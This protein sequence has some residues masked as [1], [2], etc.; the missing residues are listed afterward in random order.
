MKMDKDTFWQIIDSVNSEVSGADPQEILRATRE[1][2]L[3][4][5]PREI[6]VWANILRYYRELA[7]T[8]GIF[9]ASCVL[10]EYMSDDGFMDFRAWLISSGKEVYLAALKNP[11]SLAGLEIPENTRFELYGYVAYDAFKS[12]CRDDVYEVMK[13]NPLTKAHKA[14]IRAEIKYFPLEIDYLHVKLHLPDLYAKHM[15]PGVGL[16]FIYRQGS[17]RNY[18][19][20][21]PDMTELEKL[22]KAAALI[23]EMTGGRQT[24]RAGIGGAYIVA[25]EDADLGMQ[26]RVKSSDVPDHFR[27]AFT[28]YSRKMG[29]EMASGGLRSL[30]TEAGQ[31][32][33]LLMALE[34]QDFHPSSGEL[35]QFAEGIEQKQET[36]PVM[37][38]TF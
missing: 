25:A 13:R 30:M 8:S 22:E 10:N 14:D 27:I 2:L 17:R 29:G 20:T 15:E 34:M 1:K 21:E 36:G 3:D 35:H 23:E 26:M 18:D 24:F 5:S 37:G 11:D 4:Y 12:K 6:A 32:Y 19:V 28:A 38:Q 31:M 33:A 7:D 16:S 9:A